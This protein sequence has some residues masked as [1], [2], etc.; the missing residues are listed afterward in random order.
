MNARPEHPTTAETTTTGTTWEGLAPELLQPFGTVRYRLIDKD[1]GLLAPYVKAWEYQARLDQLVGPDGWRMELDAV[2]NTAVKCRLTIA[3][4]VREDIGTGND[5]KGAASDALKRACMSFGIGR[6]LRSLGL[7]QESDGPAPVDDHGQGSAPR[8]GSAT[9]RRPRPNDRRHGRRPNGSRPR[10]HDRHRAGR[11]S[12][13]T[14]AG[15]APGAGPALPL[16]TGGR[17][18]CHA[19]SARPSRRPGIVSGSTILAGTTS[20]VTAGSMSN[21][22]HSVSGA[23]RG[24]ESSTGAVSH[25]PTIAVWAA[26]RTR[27]RGGR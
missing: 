19:M 6:W 15:P 27:Q 11:S 16:T 7:R 2:G 23:V 21:T 20:A 26:A 1:K 13:T 14:R 10:R 12:T 9:A 22:G 5:L 25:G 18:R 4:V 24:R 17:E 3:G 8:Q